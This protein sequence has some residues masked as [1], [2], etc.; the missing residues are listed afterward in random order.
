[1]VGSLDFYRYSKKIVAFIIVVSRV[2][3]CATNMLSTP[4]SRRRS[5]GKARTCRWEAAMGV[6]YQLNVPANSKL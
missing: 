6:P 4:L 1:M 5:K 3:D 2:V